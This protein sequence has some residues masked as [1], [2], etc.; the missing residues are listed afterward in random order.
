MGFSGSVGGLTQVSVCTNLSE[1]NKVLNEKG[2]T[3]ISTLLHVP[4]PHKNNIFHLAWKNSQKSH[5]ATPIPSIRYLLRATKKTK[6]K[7][8]VGFEPLDY[9]LLQSTMDYYV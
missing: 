6:L 8:H 1:G 9:G 3:P 5:S 2:Y 7:I 4:L